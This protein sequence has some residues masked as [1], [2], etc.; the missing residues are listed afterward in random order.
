MSEPTHHAT[1]GFS[2][3]NI[4]N[5]Y[6]GRTGADMH[7]A[8]SEMQMLASSLLVALFLETCDPRSPDLSLGLFEGQRVQ[9]Q[10]AH[11]RRI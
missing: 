6:L 4:K 1:E 5:Q 10:P 11:I 9:K 7:T 8:N 2:R 3:N